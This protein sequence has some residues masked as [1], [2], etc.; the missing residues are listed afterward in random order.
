MDL[1]GRIAG[2]K[3]A[4]DEDLVAEIPTVLFPTRTGETWD[5]GNKG[6]RFVI[7]AP[8]NSE[9]NFP[10]TLIINWLASR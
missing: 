4:L 8:E 6:E 1:K 9:A 3:V 2:V 5:S 7:G 10:I